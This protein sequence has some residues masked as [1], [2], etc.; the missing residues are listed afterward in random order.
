MCP[1]RKPNT[2]NKLI[3]L[4]FI[5]A[6]LSACSADIS[7]DE[8]VARAIEQQSEGDVNAAV[9]ELKNAL[10][11]TPRHKE[12]RYLLGTLYLEQG[13]LISAEKEFYRAI[14]YGVEPSAVA[15][16]LARTLLAQG[17]FQELLDSTN[18]LS[19]TSA[20]TQANLLALKGQAYLGLARLDAAEQLY[21]QALQLDEENA[22]A[23]TGLAQLAIVRNQDDAARQYVTA[24]LKQT[25]NFAFAQSLLGLIELRASNL[26]A[27]EQ[28]YRSAA[29]HPLY[30]SHSQIQLG[31]IYIQL[32][33]F[34]KAEEMV[35]LLKQRI[36]GSP[37]VD[38]LE[39]FL[40][41]NQQNF[42]DAKDL[43][44]ALLGKDPNHLRGLFYAG[45]TNAYLGNFAS[46]KNQLEQHLKANPGNVYAQTLLAQV[47]LAEGNPAH[48]QHLILSVLERFPDDLMALNLLA[49]VS[50]SQGSSQEALSSLQKAAQAQ[51]TSVETQIRL[52]NL[53][54]G[55]GQ[56][57]ASLLQLEQAYESEPDNGRVVETLVRQYLSAGENDKALAVAEKH[58]ALNP[59]RPLPHALMGMVFMSLNDNE[60]A[61][62][63][64]QRALNIDPSATSIYNGLAALAIRG[65]ELDTAEQHLRKALSYRP[66]DYQ[67]VTNLVTLKRIQGKQADIA[68]ILEEAVDVEP[69]V[70]FQLRL[71]RI[72]LDDNE[73]QRT[74]DL[75]SNVQGSNN[76]QKANLLGLRAEAL[77]AVGQYSDARQALNELLVLAPKTAVVH[78]Y[79]AQAAQGLNERVVMREELETAT[80]LDA[81]Y[82]PAKI[83]LAR[84]AIEDRDIAVAKQ[85]LAE[86][87]GQVKPDNADVT[88]IKAQLSELTND[89]PAA[90]TAYQRLF[91]RNP[92]ASALLPLTRA[93]WRNGDK[94]IALTSLQSWTEANPRERLVKH[95]LALRYMALQRNDDAVATYTALIKNEPEDALALNNLAS[96]LTVSK[97]KVALDYARRA[98]A[99]FPEDPAAI[100]TLSG[101]MLANNDIVGAQRMIERALAKEPNN[102]AFLSRQEQIQRVSG[103]R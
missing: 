102:T 25:P 78:F 34:D 53:L 57:E 76:T 66:G 9:I 12:A 40:A 45:S 81:N 68:N 4:F 38:Y 101:A 56:V 5:V 94:D 69:R 15:V 7:S 82:L 60:A 83:A 77:L 103:Q 22:E 18:D 98:Y 41:F 42:K 16:P 31:F 99:L 87:E 100:D 28:A 3:L 32:K 10:Q 91:D 14:D 43:F 51:P 63:A 64:L 26:E 47:E 49:G 46:A 11:K 21:D 96:L 48:A 59:N 55:Q 24:V 85:W 58:L 8:Y 97:P 23:K 17:K 79:L 70:E 52:G 80:Q 44:D 1:H 75:L 29:E 37:Q 71:G 90:I 61:E 39:G 19:F 88:L 6:G 95:D 13:A 54:A 62:E 2:I 50:L 27:A 65:E 35:A 33:Q 67:T 30:K 20:Y 86:L 84:M 93:Q 89:L 92:S 74:L 72:Y 73:P 36:K